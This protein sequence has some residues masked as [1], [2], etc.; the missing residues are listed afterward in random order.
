MELA[1]ALEI[2]KSAMAKMSFSSVFTYSNCLYPLMFNIRLST[3]SLPQICTTWKSS[4]S[5]GRASRTA[6]FTASAPK[7]PPMT[8]TTGLFEVNLHKS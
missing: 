3:L 5:F 8:M 1:P 4:S 2:T 6:L 7:L